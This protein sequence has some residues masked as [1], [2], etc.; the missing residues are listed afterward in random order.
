LNRSDHHDEAGRPAPAP[1]DI[2]EAL[3]RLRPRLGIFSTPIVW[4]PEITSTN[5]VAA[6]LG[7][8]GAPEGTIVAADAQTAGRGRLRRAW[9][10]PPGAG[11]YLSL[12]LRPTADAAALLTIAAGVAIAEGIE[13]STGL[14]SHVK[15]PNDI[16][17]SGRKLAG[18]LAEA[19]SRSS[20][21]QYVVLGCGINVMPAAYPPDV[22]QRATSIESELGRPVDRGLVLAECLAALASRYADLPSRRAA[23]VDAWRRRAALTFG[24]PVAWDAAGV[25]CRGVAE[26]VDDG[27]ALLVRTDAGIA[28]IMSGEV[29]WI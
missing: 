10:S 24:R 12:V 4:Y 25:R 17:V 20:T 15:W 29:Q 8:Q 21:L 5:D 26:D 18:I 6:R 9:S 23:I 13:A 27:G 28:R 22:A 2:V 16:Y 19:G 1:G 11:V 3:T 14:I 7:D